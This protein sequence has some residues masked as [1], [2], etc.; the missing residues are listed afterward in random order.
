MLLCK[1]HVNWISRGNKNSRT[2]PATVRL[3][4][5]IVH[6]STWP[7]WCKNSS[8]QTC[9]QHCGAQVPSMTCKKTSP[10]SIFH[11]FSVICLADPYSFWMSEDPWTLHTL[12]IRMVIAF[13]P[14]LTATLRIHPINTSQW[15][16]KV[17]PAIRSKYE[18][19]GGCNGSSHW[20]LSQKYLSNN[21]Q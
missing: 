18:A 11:P 1:K 3:P 6:A 10:F 8:R 5:R 4:T 19:A 13:Q 2:H 7:Q 15:G 14:P 20:S 21:T 16:T 9:K 12:P 17:P